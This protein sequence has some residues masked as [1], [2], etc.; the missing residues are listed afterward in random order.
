M[1]MGSQKPVVIPPN[2]GKSYSQLGRLYSFKLWSEETNGLLSIVEISTPP[3]SGPPLHIHRQEDQTFYIVEGEFE[4][5]C[6]DQRFQVTRGAITFLPRNIP[7][8]YKNCGNSSGTLLEINTPAGF[9]QFY[10]EVNLLPED[11][12]SDMQKISEIAKKFDLE[13]LLQART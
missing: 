9:E 4:I 12:S 1:T 11:E 3:Q 8:T 10:E 2:A 7:H 6:G 5:Q 13:L